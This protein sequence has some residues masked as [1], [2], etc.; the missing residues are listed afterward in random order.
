MTKIFFLLLITTSLSK[1]CAS[2]YG[3]IRSPLARAVY[4][5]MLNDEEERQSSHEE[6][7]VTVIVFTSLSVHQG[8]IHEC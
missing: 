8:P 5:R 3:R 4:T 1:I 2:M 7:I 6:V